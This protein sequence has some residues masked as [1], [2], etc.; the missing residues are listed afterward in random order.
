MQHPTAIVC[1][2]RMFHFQEVS[3]QGK[4]KACFATLAGR[5]ARF[6]M[7]TKMSDQRVTTIENA[8]VSALSAFSPHLVKSIT[9][10]RDTEFANWL[11]IEELLYCDVYFSDPYCTWQKVQMKIRMDCFG[12]FI[13]RVEICPM[14]FL[15]H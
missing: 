10:D 1:H 8:I 7:V 13:P 3:G 12:S 2:H 5:K 14:L 6:Y 11:Q 4:S 9:C 15:P